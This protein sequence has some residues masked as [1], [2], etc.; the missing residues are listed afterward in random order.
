MPIT[1]GL[2][3]LL[4]IRVQLLQCVPKGIRLLKGL[5]KLAKE[6]AERAAVALSEP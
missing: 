5:K 1:E 3:F 6:A 2:D 4:G